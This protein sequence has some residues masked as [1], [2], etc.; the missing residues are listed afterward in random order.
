MKVNANLLKNGN[1]IRHAN[2]MYQVIG[3][4]IIKPGK[5]G[6]YIQVEMRDLITGLKTNER[7]RTSENIEKLTTED[8]KCTFLFKDNKTITLMNNENFEQFQLEISMLKEKQ[9]LLEDGM[10]LT[11]E[12]VDG[13]IINVR[14]P[15]SIEVKLVYADAVVKGQTASTSYKNAETHNG[16]KLL[17]P[18]HIKEGD[19]IIINTENFDYLEKSK[20]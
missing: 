14:F 2:K 9:I 6:A 7:W 11:C 19:K 18:P 17:V 13:K 3:T 8:F 12:L 1:V 5:G 20:G 10:Q 15:K 4:N 16:I